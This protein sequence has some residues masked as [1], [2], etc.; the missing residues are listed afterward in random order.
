MF[1]GHS[2]SRVTWQVT[3]VFTLA[4]KLQPAIIFIDEVGGG[5]LAG[6][7]WNACAWF[8]VAEVVVFLLCRDQNVTDCAFD[9]AITNCGC[10]RGSCA[11]LRYLQ[12]LTVITYVRQCAPRVS[13]YLDDR[14]PDADVLNVIWAE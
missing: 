8:Y 4:W 9:L 12:H 14:I 13:R 11:R 7:D 1:A 6:I 2:D 3:A 5:G 10:E